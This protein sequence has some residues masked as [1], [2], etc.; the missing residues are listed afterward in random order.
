MRRPV[1]GHSPGRRGIRSFDGCPH[2]PRSPRRPRRRRPSSRCEG[3]HQGLPHGRG[4]GAA[5]CAASTST[6]TRGELVVLLGPSGSGKSTLLN[7]LGG[8]DAPTSRQRA[9]PRPRPDARC[10]RTAL[11][12][13]RREH[14]GFVFQFYNL[15]PSLTARENVALVTEI[16]DGPDDARRG[17]AAGR[18][19]R[20]R[21]TTSR[22]SSPAASSSAWRSPAPS[23][24]GPDVLLCDE[25][26]GALDVA[27]GK[28]VLEAHRARQ[29]RARDDHRRHH[30]QRRDRRHGRPRAAVATGASCAGR[31]PA[32][33]S[34][35]VVSAIRVPPDDQVTILVSALHQPSSAATSGSCARPGGEHRPAQ[36]ARGV[37]RR[38]RRAHGLSA[39]T[40]SLRPRA[41]L[42][43]AQ[44]LR[45]RLR[46][47]HARAGRARPRIAAIPGVS[48][49][50]R[51]H[52]GRR[53]ARRAGARRAGKSGQLISLPRGALP[54]A[55]ER[56][57]IR[58]GA[59]RP[60]PERPDEVLVSAAFAEANGSAPGDAL[61]AV[62]RRAPAPPARRRGGA[63]AGVR[64]RGAADGIFPDDR[65]YGVLWMDGARSRRR[66]IRGRLQRRRAGPR[67]RRASAPR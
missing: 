22:R 38:L 49:G 42:L 2:L 43:H 35:P 47:A 8:L 5:P 62:H 10:R 57:C 55:L 64:L 11:T 26:T 33:R 4:R 25:P 65:R 67:A 45:R 9:L 29:P 66:S 19:R 23:P 37:A 20:P 58:R 16:A 13:Y 59:A 51:A 50:R 52:G 61:G 54:A 7:I 56:T 44:P 46:L 34:R 30:P 63:L 17:A 6:S 14:V 3:A 36:P 39:P 27:T 41:T 40:R 18:P 53:A 1:A 31:T 60:M 32:R 12:R 21:S 48:A 28:L 24:S 15:I